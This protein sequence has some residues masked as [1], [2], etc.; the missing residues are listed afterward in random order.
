MY[1]CLCNS[2]N[3]DAVKDAARAGARSP[4]GV[5]RHHGTK[6]ECGQC[7]CTMNEIVR[8]H[9]RDERPAPFASAAE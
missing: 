2:L 6:V 7:L 4:Q 1:V 3:E 9:A 5:H 8:D